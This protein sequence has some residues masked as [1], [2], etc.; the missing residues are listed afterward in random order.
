MIDLDKHTARLEALPLFDAISS[1]QSRKRLT[2]AR[3]EASRLVAWRSIYFRR[4]K[5]SE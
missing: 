2:G 3:D 4:P 1:G 5:R